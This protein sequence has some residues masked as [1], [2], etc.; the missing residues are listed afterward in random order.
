MRYNDDEIREIH[1]K[2]ISRCVQLISL[3]SEKS[4]N[5]QITNEYLS[6][7]GA[8]LSIYAL[9]TALYFKHEAY[10]KESEFRFLEILG[11][12]K[13]Q[14]VKW[15]ARSNKLVSYRDFD[16]RGIQ[17]RVLKRIIIG[18]AA[19]RS[20]AKRFVNECLIAY[21]P[22]NEGEVEISYCDIPYRA[23]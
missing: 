23:E 19:N 6:N 21:H 7:L 22:K 5:G 4:C 8:V 17:P 12:N 20:K 3:P 11:R 14:N 2:L 10:E 16:W 15:R 13:D 9:E 18:P 1:R